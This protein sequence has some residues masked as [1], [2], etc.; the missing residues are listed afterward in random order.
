ML[1]APNGG[2]QMFVVR[3]PFEIFEG[4]GRITLIFETEG[5]NRPRTIHM[6]EKVQPDG[7]YPSFNGHSI[8][9]WEGRALVVDTIGFNGRG[10]LLGGLQKS[11]QTHLVERFTWS[12]DGKVMTDTLTVEDPVSLLKPWTVSLVFD[13]MA[14][15][16]E[17]LEVWCEV[18]LEAFKRADPRP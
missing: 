7:I 13:R 16:E 18:D 3:S 5:N 4:F 1:R 8:G 12:R 9:R 17:R 2:P 15:T 11:V 10:P 6:N 14:D